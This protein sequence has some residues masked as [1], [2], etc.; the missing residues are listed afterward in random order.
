V[1]INGHAQDLSTVEGMGWD[2][3]RAAAVN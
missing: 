1:Y 3:H 2:G